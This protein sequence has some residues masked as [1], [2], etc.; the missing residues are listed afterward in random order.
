[1]GT[2][3][4]K[5]GTNA[6]ANEKQKELN[7]LS[8]RIA[9]KQ[10]QKTLFRKGIAAMA[11]EDADFVTDNIDAIYLL[12]S[13]FNETLDYCE[14]K[15]KELIGDVVDNKV[16]FFLK[17]IGLTRLAGTSEEKKDVDL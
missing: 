11:Q 8:K 3:T 4:V 17:H 2:E 9:R 6:I 1:M 13:E 12:L 7:E 15:R 16:E 10:A 14:K 5:N